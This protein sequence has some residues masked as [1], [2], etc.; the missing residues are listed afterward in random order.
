MDATDKAIDGEKGKLE[1]WLTRGRTAM[2]AALVAGALVVFVGYMLGFTPNPWFWLT[3]LGIAYVAYVL[4]NL[5]LAG[6]LTD[7]RKFT[8]ADPDDWSPS[9]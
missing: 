6:K 5:F 4:V 3:A 9:T 7:Q 8:E 1:Q 2:L